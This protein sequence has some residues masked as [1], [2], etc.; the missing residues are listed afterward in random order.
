MMA[1]RTWKRSGIFLFLVFLIQ[2]GLES[3]VFAQATESEASKDIKREG[4][5]L[6]WEIPGRIAIYDL[7]FGPAL[8]K[9]DK[10]QFV[11]NTRTFNTDQYP[12]RLT[13]MIRFSYVGSRSESPLKFV[14]KLPNSR[15]YEETVHLTNKRGNHTYHF[16]VQR[17]TDFLG[18]GS[19]YIY[20]GF[21]IVDVL[22]FTI[23]PGS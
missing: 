23:V 12:D 7:Q 4:G 10:F 19:V 14:I 5:E 13:L 11:A 9:D 6:A 1:F 21:N 16:T 3:N 22:D 20:Y 18:A 8:F 2:F 15:Q 17:P